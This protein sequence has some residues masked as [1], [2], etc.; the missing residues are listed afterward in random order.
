MPL[1]W[2]ERLEKKS[3][4]VPIVV[5][6]GVVFFYYATLLQRRVALSRL[7]GRW[8]CDMYLDDSMLSMSNNNWFDF[9]VMLF[10][11]VCSIFS[12][13]PFEFWPWALDLFFF[14]TISERL[15]GAMRASGAECLDLWHSNTNDSIC[16]DQTELMRHDLLLCFT[17]PVNSHSTTS[18]TC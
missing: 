5:M 8:P 2:Q 14:G 18:S 15:R 10:V 6:S 7:W 11:D 1:Q 3:T 9:L 16:Y 13:T 17:H 12:C 4:Q